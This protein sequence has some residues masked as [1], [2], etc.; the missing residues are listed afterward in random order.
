MS[1]ILHIDTTLEQAFISVAKEGTTIQWSVN[2][3]QK[4]HAS[5]IQPAIQS[6]LKKT[7]IG[8]RELNAVAVTNGPGS[9]TGIRVGMSTAKGLC[10]ALNIPLI[11]LNT[12]E[13]L[14]DLGIKQFEHSISTPSLFCPMIDA[15]RMEV[16]TAIYDDKLTKITEPVALILTNDLSDLIPLTKNV[17]FFGSG[18]TKW[19]KICK[20][21]NASFPKIEI[22][23]LYMSSLA[24]TKFQNM[25]FSSIAY[26]QA[27]YIKEFREGS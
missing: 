6:L 9:Y 24:F 10:Y 7:G 18:S 12:L 13:T 1:T 27:D 25:D 14:A 15:R 19:Q 23:A 2:E 3:S 11:I 26:A 16:F 4:E 8:I 22:N 20:Y 21:P 17:F 5:F